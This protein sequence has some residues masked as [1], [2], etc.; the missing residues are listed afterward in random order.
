M[1]EYRAYNEAGV[2]P[3]LQKVITAGS[4]IYVT[5]LNPNNEDELAEAGHELVNEHMLNL[6]E[7]SKT[8][9]TSMEMYSEEE[10]GNHPYPVKNLEEVVKYTDEVCKWWM[11]VYEVTH[12]HGMKLVLSAEDHDA[13]HALDTPHFHDEESGSTVYIDSAPTHTHDEAT[14]DVVYVEAT[15]TEETPA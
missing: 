7:Y 12:L 2:K 9:A 8:L 14:G 6:L 1:I 13:L 5:N 4:E 11:Y 10:A 15:T 3:E